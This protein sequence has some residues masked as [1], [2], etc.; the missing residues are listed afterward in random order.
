MDLRKEHFRGNATCQAWKTSNTHQ[1]KCIKM[2]LYAPI[3]ASAELRVKLRTNPSHIR[4]YSLSHGGR[5][6]PILLT[7]DQEGRA[8]LLRST[9][10][11]LDLEVMMHED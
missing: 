9:I 6:A 1:R 3:Q 8:P 7:K 4:T 5:A 2:G 10:M 11:P